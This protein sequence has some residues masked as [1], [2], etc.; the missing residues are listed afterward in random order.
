[1]KE[2][3]AFNL[4]VTPENSHS[5]SSYAEHALGQIAVGDEYGITSDMVRSF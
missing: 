1:M 4:K 2:D 5:S 3:T